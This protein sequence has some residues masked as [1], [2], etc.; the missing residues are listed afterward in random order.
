MRFT[1]PLLSFGALPDP[2][3]IHRGPKQDKV[4]CPASVKAAEA[5]MVIC[6]SLLF[7]ELDERE[8]HYPSPLARLFLER[9]L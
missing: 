1:R 3:H 7:L 9:D 4:C 6:L 5:G 8:V 2:K